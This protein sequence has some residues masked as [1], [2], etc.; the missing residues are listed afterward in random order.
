MV[1]GVGD[2]GSNPE[3]E[4]EAVGTENRG[5]GGNEWNIVENRK[6]KKN[7]GQVSDSDSE[8]VKHQ[9]RRRKEQ[10]KVMI[11]FNSKSISAIKLTK[12]INE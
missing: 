11:K 7:W 1:R 9:V 2:S 4:E 12:A 8:K 5:S 3:M 6:R 10:H